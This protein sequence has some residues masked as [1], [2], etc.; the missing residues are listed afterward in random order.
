MRISTLYT[1]LAAPTSSRY[2]SNMSEQKVALREQARQHREMTDI[3][4]ED[5]EAATPIF[6]DTIQPK[7]EHVIAAYW[8][9]GREFD[10]THIL[11]TALSKGYICALPK[12]ETDGR[13]L[14]FV[15]WDQSVELKKG[16]YGIM[17]P[18]TDDFIEPDIFIVPMLSFDRKGYRLGQG[19]GYYDATLAY[20]RDM[21]EITAIGIGYAH[22]AVLFTLPVED[23][24]QK[25]DYILTPQGITDHTE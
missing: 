22:Q 2:S 18:N 21:K 19:G 16:A 10:P 9:K 11:E 23:H 5:V 15:K 1:A 13:I 17:E 25:M 7:Q 8:P 14:K 24:D 4:G 3:R 20:Y 6:F 12:V